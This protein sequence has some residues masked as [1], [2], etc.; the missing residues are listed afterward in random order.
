[1]IT[2]HSGCDGTPMNSMEYLR[3][4]VGTPVD[5]LEI[6]VRRAQ[7]GALAL[8]H[9][10]VSGAPGLTLESAFRF[11]SQWNVQINCDMKQP[12]LE[13]E[14]LDCARRCGVGQSR[15]IFTGRAFGRYPDARVFVNAEELVPGFDGQP[16]TTA[17][18]LRRCREEGY[19]VINLDYRL[20]GERFMRACARAGVALSVWTVDDIQAIGMLREAGVFNITTHIVRQVFQA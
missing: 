10:P 20:C 8:S 3:H 13:Q 2:A 4:A 7:G 5:A 6:D 19:D 1:M 11:L 12:A 16:G 17:A 14:V 18:L 9:N 15:I